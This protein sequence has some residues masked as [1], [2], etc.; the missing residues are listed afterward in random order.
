MPP[1]HVSGVSREEASASSAPLR[2]A[3]LSVARLNAILE[4]ADDI[5]EGPAWWARV[6]KGG[7]A[8]ASLVGTSPHAVAALADLLTLR[9]HFGYLDGL[10]LA[11]VGEA[12]EFAHA[13]VEAAT[14]AGLHVAAATP[15]GHGPDHE[16]TMGALASAARHGG[17]VRLGHDPRA[18]VALADVVYT[19]AW[20]SLLDVAPEA[21]F[22]HPR[23]TQPGDELPA[24]VIDGPRSLVAEQA[25][26]R[27]PTE[28][29]VLHTLATDGR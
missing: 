3:D 4:L 23:P 12:D 17:S 7:P 21:L 20:A 8:E 19:D 28:Q 1:I 27:P 16:H 24:E 29:A 22:M 26:N 25:A 2:V 5:R 10:R 14:L 9:R 18:A 13:L 6:H 11:Y 15:P